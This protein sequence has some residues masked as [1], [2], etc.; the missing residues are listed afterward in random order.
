LLQIRETASEGVDSIPK[1]W[2]GL[3]LQV[4]QW[5]E[6][7]EVEPSSILLS[8]NQRIHSEVTNLEERTMVLKHLV[9]EQIGGQILLEVL[10]NMGSKRK[11]FQRKHLVLE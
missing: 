2:Q 1:T 5:V 10:D 3:D 9:M 4:V 6:F 11:E 7:L 8:A